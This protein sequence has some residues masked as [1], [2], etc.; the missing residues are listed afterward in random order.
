MNLHRQRVLFASLLK[1]KDTNM[2]RW[3]TKHASSVGIIAVCLLSLAACSRS[4]PSAIRRDPTG[5]GGSAAGAAQLGG[6]PAHGQAVFNRGCTS[7]HATTTEKRVGPGLAGLFEPGGPVLP[8]GVDYG[9]TLPNKQPITVDNVKAWIRSGG[10]GQIG[11]MPPNGG[12]ANL[13]EEDLNNVV[14]YLHTLKQ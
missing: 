12:L 11:A 13:S 1:N 6:D 4:D 3:L 14:A 8:A 5:A 7:C 10:Q 9:G 2:Q